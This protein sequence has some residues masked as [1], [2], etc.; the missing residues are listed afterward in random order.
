MS[1]Q[2]ATALYTAS[3]AVTGG[4]VGRAVSQTGTLALDLARPAVRGTD[5]G[6]DP[7]E[8]FAAGYAACFDSA[9][10]AAARRE[11]L[12]V[13]ATTTTA[14]VTLHADE[15]Q[16][17]SISVELRVSAPDCPTETLRRVAELAD[18]TCPYSKALRGNVAVRITV[19]GRD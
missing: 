3:V 18:E 9:I 6:T 1:T 15:E 5:A 16:Q 14:S 2:S 4:R 11:R 19:H 8:L 17:Y 13:G 12:R 7:E 10:A